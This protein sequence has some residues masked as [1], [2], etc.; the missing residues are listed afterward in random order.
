MRQ[1]AFADQID[2]T[3][4]Q[5]LALDKDGFQRSLTHQA[6]SKAGDE[7]GLLH[8]PLR[9]AD[10]TLALQHAPEPLHQRIAADPLGERNRSSWICFQR[11]YPSEQLGQYTSI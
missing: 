10:Q 8:A 9:T 5:W 6:G 3:L 11:R 1:G 2:E 4:R 7:A